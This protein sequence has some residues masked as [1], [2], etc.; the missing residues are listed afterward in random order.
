M[1]SELGSARANGP[2]AIIVPAPPWRNRAA[3]QCAV[4]NFTRC[5]AIPALA[6][7]ADMMPA[8]GTWFRPQYAEMKEVAVPT[9]S[10]K[11]LPG[12]CGAFFRPQEPFTAL[13]AWVVDNLP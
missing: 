10:H 12:C 4:V 11:V 2:V 13:K 1:E 3:C 7:R 6:Q 5:A 9:A 8:A